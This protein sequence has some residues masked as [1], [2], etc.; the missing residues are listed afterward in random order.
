MLVFV[1]AFSYLEARAELE[2]LGCLFEKRKSSIFSFSGI[3]VIELI[4]LFL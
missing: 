2:E 4:S 3:A 1:I